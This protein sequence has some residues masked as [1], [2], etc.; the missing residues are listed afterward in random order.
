M[1][2]G[3]VVGDFAQV[4]KR[5]LRNDTLDSRL[6]SSG[7]KSYRGAHRFAERE[8]TMGGLSDEE[9]V[10]NRVRVITLLPAESDYG[11]FTLAVSARIHH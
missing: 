4:P 6:N 5:A 2:S 7:L 10:D 9:S 3:V 11:S 8:Q 1:Q